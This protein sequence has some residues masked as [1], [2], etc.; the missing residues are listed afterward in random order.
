M[1]SKTLLPKLLKHSNL[2]FT[3]FSR[4]INP[5]IPTYK[6][7]CTKVPNNSPETPTQKAS[8]MVNVETKEERKVNDYF[9]NA[10]LYECV[11]YRYYR[12]ELE[13]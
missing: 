10:N 8:E 1:I 4:H 13:S 3:P 11:I 12:R 9:P 6:S 5:F 7:Y 2:K